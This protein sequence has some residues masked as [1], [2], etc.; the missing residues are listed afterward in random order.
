MK[1]IIRK[2]L[3]YVPIT[4]AVVALGISAVLLVSPG[5][6]VITGMIEVTEIDVAPKIPGRVDS[7]LVREGDHIRK[8][9]L[10]ASLES[11]EIDAKVEQ[12]RGAMDAALAKLDMTRSG[13]RDEERTAVE[14]LHLQTKHKFELAEK[15]YDRV[16]ALY[17]DSVIST[18]ERDEVEFK[19]KAAREQM[20]AAKAKYDMVMK[21]ARSEQIRAAEG[22]FHQAESAFNE[23]AA[24]RQELRLISP[25]DGEVS[26]RIIDPG[27]IVAAGYPVISVLDLRDVWAVIQLREDQMSEVRKGMRVNAVIPAV[28]PQEQEFEISYLSPMADFS[29]WRA[30]SQKGEFDLKTFEV[31]LRPVELID[32][33]HPGM[34]IRVEL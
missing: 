4:L 24:Y 2:L 33:M 15:T 34:T 17:T 32:G 11:K 22:L 30:T 5:K 9:Q 16:V 26:Q 1:M 14:K 28:G 7:V 13:A 6:I 8:G 31:H 18:Q 12:A 21:G 10:L 29:T 25:I 23:A 20:E 27:E 3:I 19:Y